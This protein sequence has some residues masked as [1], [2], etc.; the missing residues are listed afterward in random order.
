MS[1]DICS[2]CGRYKWEHN[3][4]QIYL[5]EYRAKKRKHEPT[6]RIE[7]VSWEDAEANCPEEMEVIG[8]LLYEMDAP[9]C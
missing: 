7:A 3:L 4:T 9:D 1:G 2:N 6:P 8:R 5:T